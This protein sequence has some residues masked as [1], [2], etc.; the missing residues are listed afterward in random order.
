MQTKPGI[1]AALVFCALNLISIAP[2]MAATPPDLLC[3]DD[4]LD[5]GERAAIARLFAEPS[6]MA[7]ATDGEEQGADRRL[8][9]GT[10]EASSDFAR[11]IGVCAERFN[12]N[13][14]Q[15]SMASSYLIQLG[16]VSIIAL[17][18]GDDWHDAMQRY[19]RFGT[20]LMPIEGEPSAHTRTLLAAGAH[21]NGVPVNTN[22]ESED[23]DIVAYF[24]AYRKLAQHIASFPA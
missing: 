13:E 6:E 5:L 2:A 9:D 19:F 16:N 21:A 24:L 7:N 23:S 8:G 3:I 11:A 1:T 17:R 12:W 15:R 20:R 10:P 4:Q 22:D 14:A 18:N